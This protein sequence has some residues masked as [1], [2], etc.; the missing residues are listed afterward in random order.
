MTNFVHERLD[1]FRTSVQRDASIA[2]W[3]AHSILDGNASGAAFAIACVR[4]VAVVK[5]VPKAEPFDRFCRSCF[6]PQRKLDRI[7]EL[8]CTRVF[9]KPKAFQTLHFEDGDCHAVAIVRNVFDGDGL[10]TLLGRA[11]KRRVEIPACN[12]AVVVI[13]NENSSGSSKLRV[14]CFH[15]ETTAATLHD[16][17]ADAC[18]RAAFVG[19]I[20]RKADQRIVQRIAAVCVR[21]VGGCNDRVSVDPVA[22]LQPKAG[23]RHLQ[24]LIFVY[25]APGEPPGCY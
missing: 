23:V 15:E 1:C 14:H 4:V 20:M 13:I 18:A 16:G 19:T 5:Q 22:G 12:P 7:R 2:H 8:C 9:D 17:D 25:D 3:P 10:G 11:P 6:R 21:R 24:A